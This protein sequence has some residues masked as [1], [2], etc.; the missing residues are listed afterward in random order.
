[1]LPAAGTALATAQV[2]RLRTTLIKQA[3]KVTL[4]VRRVLVEMSAHCPWADTIQQIAQR[5]NSSEIA[6]LG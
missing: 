3:A 5:L 4:S 1:M 6:L 2:E